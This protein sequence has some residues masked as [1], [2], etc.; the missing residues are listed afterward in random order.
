MY[1]TI[2]LTVLT[3]LMSAAG[4]PDTLQFVDG[5]IITG[6]WRGGDART[7]L[8]E[9]AGREQRFLVSEVNKLSFDPP[10]A[11]ITAA[12]ANRTPANGSLNTSPEPSLARNNAGEQNPSANP[13]LLATVAGVADNL[14]YINSGAT[15]GLRV[16]QMFQVYRV[17]AG[18]GNGRGTTLTRR[19]FICTLTL[20]D[21]QERSAS[22]T[23]RGDVP[24]RLDVAESSGQTAPMPPPQTASNS[25]GVRNDDSGQNSPEPRRIAPSQTRENFSDTYGVRLNQ[26]W[27]DLLECMSRE[28]DGVNGPCSVFHSSA[29][30]LLRNPP[31]ENWRQVVFP[32]SRQIQT[33]GL[34]AYVQAQGGIARLLATTRRDL[35]SAQDRAR[36]APVRSNDPASELA[37]SCDA[38][39]EIS[40]R[41]ADAYVAHGLALKSA[42]FAEPFYR[43]ALRIRQQG[44]HT[45]Q[46]LALALELEGRALAELRRPDESKPLLDRAFSLRQK[47]VREMTPPNAGP[48]SLAENPQTGGDGATFRSGNGTSPPAVISK[49]NPPIPDTA[50]AAGFG[51]CSV[52]LSLIV[53]RD[54]QPSTLTLVRGCGLG[55]DEEAARAVLQ[56]R[57]RPGVTDG[58][59]VRVAAT[60]EVNFGLF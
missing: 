13:S 36:A 49:S 43:K 8:F 42:T 1:A 40:D 22:G 25:S 6:T 60:V 18:S 57:F 54:G 31:D 45:D 20:S 14:T 10:A 21:V 33:E 3:F 16:G 4:L 19:Q 51:S 46:S 41:C 39:A 11:P 27:I 23:C 32:V 12:P 17:T 55:L 37:R 7:I 34:N 26:A 35:A 59:P 9:A 2:R 58:M 15:V 53:E 28:K 52:A 50:R 44:P 48:R 30:E 47:S 56:W 38:T 29:L 5:R 24:A